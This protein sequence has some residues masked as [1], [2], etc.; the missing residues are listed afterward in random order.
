MTLSGAGEKGRKK[1]KAALEARGTG[2][3]AHLVGALA[4]RMLLAGAT[5]LGGWVALTAL[6]G[7][8]LLVPL[9]ARAEQVGVEMLARKDAG[10]AT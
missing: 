6:Y 1:K 2:F 4:F 5:P 9:A 7:R 10:M 3:A 8:G